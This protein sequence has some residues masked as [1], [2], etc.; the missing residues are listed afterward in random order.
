MERIIKISSEN[1][2]SEEAIPGTFVNSK[3]LDIVIP[4][5]GTYDLAKS[6]INL[7]MSIVQAACVA[8]PA[9]VGNGVAVV[10]I[11]DAD[12]ALYAS[13]IALQQDVTNTEKYVASVATIVRNAQMESQN[14][15]MVESIRRV[16]TLR[17]LLY[18]LENDNKEIQDGLD[19]FGTF[20][21]RRGPGNRTS[22][23]IAHCVVN[24]GV[25]GVADLTWNSN[26]LNR[27]FRVNFSDLFGV[28]NAMWNGR[29]FG[30]TR[31]NLELNVNKLR[32]I[33]LGGAENIQPVPG[34]AA[35][36]GACVD[37]NAA[38]AG[39]AISQ[40][41]TTATYKD[42]Q[43]DFPFYVGQAIEVNFTGSAEGGAIA[44]T[45]VVISAI[46]YQNNNNTN[47]PSPTAA[48]VM[49]ITT[50]TPWYTPPG[51]TNLS[52]ITIKGLVAGP[53][54]S[55]RI[56]RAELVLTE[57]IGVDGPSEIDYRTY[58]TEEQ[59]GN[60]AA[61]FFNQYAVEPNAQ[62]LIVAHC[63]PNEI[64]PDREWAEYRIAI[65]NVDQ[66]GNRSVFYRKNL[67]QDRM[68]RFMNNRGQLVSNM[69]M[70]DLNC[71][72]VQGDAQQEPLYPICETLPLTAGQKTVTLQIASVAG[73]AD[74]IAYKELV[75]TI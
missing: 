55:I 16:D 68:L 12:T 60:N 52:G 51:L 32:L 23:M 9:V 38:A 58:T 45:R 59:N 42:P 39:V 53:T 29:V 24:T 48:E 65:N 37:Q 27:D 26:E 4:S 61:N 14:R 70:Y 47:P 15:G 13:T 72:A 30:D 21:G 25:D 49:I 50:R 56:N 63:D 2:F 71:D 8:A 75:K 28:G 20:H 36:Y 43:L 57:M 73:V 40:L 5:M 22:D 11:T 10:G 33:N 31:I 34:G 3:L 44:S 64:M 1:A 69:S 74:I 6:Y 18:Y 62:N 46:S 66:T 19:K 35:T 54:S 17:T 7:N 41:V 67:H